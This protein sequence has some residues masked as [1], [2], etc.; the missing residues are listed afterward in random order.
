MQASGYLVKEFMFRSKLRGIGPSAVD[1]YVGRA[2]VY[3]YSADVNIN[4]RLNSMIQY[5]DRT[6][7]NLFYIE[8]HY[9][10]D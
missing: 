2:G 6:L 5:Y 8:N 10:F 1:I 9:I 7:E 4:G 3:A